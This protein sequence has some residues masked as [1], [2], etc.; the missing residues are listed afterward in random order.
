MSPKLKET[1]NI[2]ICPIADQGAV[3]TI[4]SDITFTSDVIVAQA[5]KQTINQWGETVAAFA[6]H[7]LVRC[8][9][10]SF[11][12]GTD[13]TSALKYYKD[14]LEMCKRRKLGWLMN[15][16]D[17]GG[18]L[19]TDPQFLAFKFGGGKATLYEKDICYGQALYLQKDLLKL[20]QTYAEKPKKI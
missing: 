14:F 3:L 6:P 20:F 16:Y 9:A 12:N 10:A 8:E 19:S 11:C 18:M 4:H 2:M 5:N 13:L 1:S 7:A 17:I 15:D